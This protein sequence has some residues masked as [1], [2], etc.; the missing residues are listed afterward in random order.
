MFKSPKLIQLFFLNFGHW[1]WVI[2]WSLVLGI[3]DLANR[4]ALCALP[5]AVLFAAAGL[6][7]DTTDIMAEVEGFGKTSQ[8]FITS[9]MIEILLSFPDGSGRADRQAVQAGTA[10]P[11]R[12]RA[13]DERNPGENRHQTD[14]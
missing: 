3:W 10:V 11:Y 1:G 6:D 4:S 9:K 8:L 7:A 14:P 2:F 13:D 12:R 5:Y